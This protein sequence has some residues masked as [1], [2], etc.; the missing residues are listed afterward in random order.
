[1][2]DSQGH[3]VDFRNTMIIMTSNLGAKH[4]ANLPQ[5][6]PSEEARTDV[7]EVVREHFAPEFLNRID[8]I[9]LFNRLTR[10]NMDYILD[11][12]ISHIR[13]LLEPKRIVFD[14]D[15]EAKHFLADSGFDPVYGARPLKRVIQTLVLNKMATMLI[16][17]ELAEGDGVLVTFDKA[18]DEL[19]F[20]TLPGKG[21]A[22]YKVPEDEWPEEKT[23]TKHLPTSI[24][25]E[26][27][28][29]DRE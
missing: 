23:K 29:Y 26:D 11:L 6:V 8:D 9:I 7:M 21:R 17:G 19:I 25:D 20:N 5:G 18:K 4:L 12:Q 1:L 22:F 2:T 24:E 3:K 15:D 27:L 28:N 16:S 10:E 13:S 14:V